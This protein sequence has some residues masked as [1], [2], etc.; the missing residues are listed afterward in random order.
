LHSCA[1]FTFGDKQIDVRQKIQSSLAP[2]SL[3]ALSLIYLHAVVAHTLLGD[4]LPPL[5]AEFGVTGTVNA[6]KPVDQA[7]Q[8]TCRD[9]GGNL[10]KNCDILS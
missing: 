9:M 8:P 3:E 4:T 6:I 2:T 10:L 5:L 1:H 7:H